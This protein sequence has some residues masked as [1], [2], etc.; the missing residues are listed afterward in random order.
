M[1]QVKRGL[2]RCGCGKRAQS[3]AESRFELSA[4]CAA[5]RFPGSDSN[6]YRE[7]VAWAAYDR[8]VRA[9]SAQREDRGSLA[10]IVGPLGEALTFRA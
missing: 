3:R 8:P 4:T 9:Q 10:P 2:C 7:L 5:A 6:A 1:Y